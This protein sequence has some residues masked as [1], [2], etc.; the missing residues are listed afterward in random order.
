MGQLYI[1]LVIGSYLDYKLLLQLANRVSGT[2]RRVVVE[3]R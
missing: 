2:A 1:Y 3:K